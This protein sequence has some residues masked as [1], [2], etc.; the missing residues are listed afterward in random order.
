MKKKIISFSL[1]GNNPMYNIG[2]EKNLI[3]QKEIYPEWICRYYIDNTI[4]KNT[5]NFLTNN[6]AEIIYKEPNILCSGAFWRYE[7]LFDKDVEISIFR[8]TDSRL[9]I[10]EKKAVDEW[11]QTDYS[12]HIMRDYPGH[13]WNIMGGMWG[14]NLLNTTPNFITFFKK[15]YYIYSQNINEY[16]YGGD[17]NFLKTIIWE[18]VKENHIAHVSFNNL[19]KTNKEK[20]FPCNFL[21][22]YSFVGNKYDQNDKAVFSLNI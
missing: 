20:P 13:V 22:K 19:I 12:V 14:I 17:E 5:L 7:A 6:G 10:R 18:K 11:L 4:N 8:D 21:D 9:S 15:M 1:W 2:A 16:K 3:L